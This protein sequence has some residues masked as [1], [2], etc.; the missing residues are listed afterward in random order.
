MAGRELRYSVFWG[1][2]IPVLQPFVEKATR[3]VF[4]RL[5]VELLEV[6]GATCCP[7]PEISRIA[8]PEAWLILASRNMAIAES[9]GVPMLILCNGCYDTFVKALKELKEAEGRMEEVRGALKG[10]SL[11]FEGKLEVRHVIEVLHDDIG[12][13]RLRERVK[14]LFRGVK[15]FIQYGCRIFRDEDTKKLPEKFD[16]L[17]S[18]LGAEPVGS[19]KRLCCGVPM[20][21]FDESRAIHERAKLKLEDARQSGADLIVTFCPACFNM[22]EKAQLAL[23]REG[24][25]FDIPIANYVELLAVAMGFEPDDFG[26]Y[27]HRIPLD[28]VWEVVGI[29]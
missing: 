3:L 10:L 2:T 22:L 21:Y 11:E 27:M 24:L 9:L 29:A 18:M 12:L 1:C 17:V 15:V 19:L 7:D 6:E 26:A 4:G 14:P 20:M 28:E 16:R 8:G 5:G 13:R 25:R 23:A